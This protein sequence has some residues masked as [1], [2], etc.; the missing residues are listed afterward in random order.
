M[1]KYI[2]FIDVDGTLIKPKSNNMPQAIVDEFNKVKKAGHI[3]VIVTGRGF[4]ETSAIDG[5]KSASFLAPIMGNIIID[6]ETGKKI[7]EPETL[8]SAAVKRFVVEVEKLGRPWSYKTDLE[9]KTYCDEEFISRHACRKVKKTEYLADLKAG[10]ICQ[11]LVEGK[12]S[13]EIIDEFKMFDFFYMPGDY[14]DVTRKGFNKAAIVKY[15]AQQYPKYQ[16]VAIGDSNND[17]AMLMEADI[18]IAM[19]NAKEELKQ[20][21]DYVTQDYQ[22]LGV[23]HAMENILKQ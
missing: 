1:Q 6:C 12:V 9:G 4:I 22:N 8:P 15:F 7:K 3:I 19:E 10:S 16:T 18:S 20:M 13:Q 5:I 14:C 17:K 23:L 21:C 2:F 11:L